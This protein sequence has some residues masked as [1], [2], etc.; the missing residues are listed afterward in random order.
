MQVMSRPVGELVT[1]RVV[2]AM[3]PTT[4][5]AA[6]VLLEQE[7]VGAVL[8]TDARGVQGIFTERDLVRAVAEGEDIDQARIGDHL[9]EELVLL[10]ASAHVLDVIQQMRGNSIRHVVVEDQDGTVGVVSMRA[11]LES[12]IGAAVVAPTG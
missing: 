1:D 2:D 11:V 3:R 12:V 6:A 5:R 8:V 9:T 10:P 4:L 7:A